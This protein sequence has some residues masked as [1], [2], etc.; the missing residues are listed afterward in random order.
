MNVDREAW[1]ERA[2]AVRIE[3]EVA[4]RGIQLKRVGAAEREG[5]C[6]VCGGTDRF[7][8]NIAKQVFNCRRC[9]KGG[10]IIGMVQHL[11]G[12]DFDGAV[13][14]LAGE[15]PSRDKRPRKSSGRDRASTRRRGGEG[16]GYI[17]TDNTSTPQRFAGCTLAAY[18]EAKRLPL[19]FL[20]GLGVSEVF[21]SGG[22]ALRI[23]YLDISG[24]EAAVRFRIALDGKNK[25]FWRKGS[26]SLL[27]GLDRID[28]AREE[29][30]IAIVEGESDCH[31]LWNAGFAAVGLPGA[32]NWNENRDAALFD[33][34]ACIYIVI[35]PDNGGEKVLKWLSQSR[36]R[37]RA[38]LVRLDPIKDVSALYLD[39]PPR[40]AER[41]RQALAVAIPWP[42]EARRTAEAEAGRMKEVAGDLIGEPDILA[43]F[44]TEVECVGLVG[45]T[46]NAKILFLSLI[47]R[48]FKRPVSVAIK[49]VSSGGKSFTVECVLR[50]FPREAYFE[51]TGLSERALAYS[52]EDFRHRHLIIYE[53]AGMTGD[54]ASYL[55]RT[56]M[57]EGRIGYELVEK[58]RDGLRSKLIEKEGP[59]GFVTTT[60][61]TKLHSENETR[62]LSLTVTDTPEQTKAVM[63]ALAADQSRKERAAD[64]WHAL[65]RWLA[66]GECRVVVPYAK[67]LA[68]LIPPA[69]V[70]LR[71]D[72][73]MLLTLI[74]AHALLH[75]ETR[76][77]DDRG[78][79]VA[80]IADY[81]VVRRLVAEVIAAGIEATVPHTVRQTVEAVRGIG[82]DEAS[83]GDL[84]KVLKLDKSA[85]SHRVRTAIGRGYL[86]NR[87]TGKGRPA[88][89]VLDDPM[90]DTIEILPAPHL[91]DR[92]GVEPLKEGIAPPP[93][94]TDADDGALD[95]SAVGKGA[96]GKERASPPLLGRC[97]Q[98][99]GEKADAPF[100]PR[101]EVHLHDQCRR[102]WH[103]DAAPPAPTCGGR[104]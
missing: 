92:C 97:A 31:T 46:T 8:I 96:A 73:G 95:S 47:S 5:P 30:A 75:R 33:G 76:T 21:H 43:R 69:A 99:N 51:R 68:E 66:L 13:T 10:D 67:T 50:F 7:S 58:T 39:D 17:P 101:L 61:A 35:E 87:E 74:R 2:R 90:P 98:C 25:F 24:N 48:L 78:S 26:K 45:E 62:L 93:S 60:T 72:F 3:D 63:I 49:G 65:Q 85:V 55:I 11:D 42:D 38:Q 16:G 40:F 34:F 36:I 27:Y 77:L 32:G 103:P 84:V 6:P 15:P 20:K 57:S 29:S 37:E 71:R 19:E 28:R 83:L 104:L 4:R 23:P 18:A 12:C 91:L 102:F 1:I 89:I 100:Y 9:C 81:A 86:A 79:I 41:L 64:Q 88:R 14:T 59:T 44:G 70:R 53:A 54:F 82:K 80:T 94:P 22:P 52:N 56:L